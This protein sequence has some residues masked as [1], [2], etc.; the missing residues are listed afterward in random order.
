[1]KVGCKGVYITRTCYHDEMSKLVKFLPKR[2]SLLTASFMCAIFNLGA[3]LH[4]GCI[5]CHLNGVLRIC[6]VYKFAPTLEVVHIYL[7]PG[8]NCAHER[9]MFN[10]YTF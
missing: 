2:D 4:P 9:K 6:T 5:F 3:N 10:F 7:H 1:M 8:S